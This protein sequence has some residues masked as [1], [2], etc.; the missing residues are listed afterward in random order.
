L[1]II[2]KSLNFYAKNQKGV[3]FGK[4]TFKYLNFCAKNDLDFKIIFKH[5]DFIAHNFSPKNFVK[6]EWIFFFGEFWPKLKS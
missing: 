4:T 6:S 1:K 3:I 5:C 2:Y